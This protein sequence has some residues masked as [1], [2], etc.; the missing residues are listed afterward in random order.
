MRV[1]LDYLPLVPMFEWDPLQFMDKAAEYGYEGVML[2]GRRLFEDEAYKQQVIE[3]KNQLDLYVEIGGAGIDSASSGRSPQELAKSWE[4]VF[5]LAQ[6]LGVKA[7]ITGLGSWPWQG[8]VNKEEGK[9]VADQIK[10]GIATLKELSSAAEDHEIAI[11]IHTAFFTADEYVQIMESVDSP[12]VGLCLDTANAFLVLEDPTEFA[13]KVAPWVKS[14]H[15]KDSCIYLQ[16]EG[17]YWFGGSPL[18][19][20]TVDLPV[21][22][23]L[24]YEANPETNLSIEDHWG[25]TPM[26]V[27]NR[28]FL[29]S[30]PGWDGSKVA[31]ML[32]HLQQGESLLR[33]GL[34]PTEE[35]SKQIDW[36]KV[37]PE[38]ARYNAI[39]AKKLRDEIVKE[40]E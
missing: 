2:A 4:S 16:P 28:E 20:G 9:S 21:I 22:L 15:L 8:R 26:P 13:R 11:T 25:R 36:K 37:F 10:G 12:Y 38:R 14:T 5:G 17:A 32:K 34:Y 40:S 19:R 30:I 39:Y 35:E 3:K 24:L 7:L 33:A 27:F 1:G 29:N 23:R 31:D 6:E 18:G